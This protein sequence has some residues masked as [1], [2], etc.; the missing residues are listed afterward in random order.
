MLAP[1]AAP[2]I[3]AVFE[4]MERGCATRVAARDGV[5]VRRS[6]D[7][8]LLRPELGDAVRRGAGRADHAETIARWS[9]ASTT[10]TSAAT[11]TASPTCPVQGVTYRV[12]AGRRRA[13]K[14]EYVAPADGDGADGAEPDRTI[15]LRHFADGAARGRRVR[16]R[17]PAGRRAASTGPAIIREGLVDDLRLPGQ[18]ARGRAASARSSIEAARDDGDPRPLDDARVRRS[19]TAATASPRPCSPT[20]SATSSST[21]AAGC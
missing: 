2:Q 15:E 16:A 21:C 14:V 6:F 17:A 13:D 11:A 4:Q 18:M 10:R 12:A 8:R 20:A 3:D 7:G 9:S 19:A 1:E 5:T